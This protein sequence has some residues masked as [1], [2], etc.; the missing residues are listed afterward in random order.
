MKPH[1]LGW[2][3]HTW[4]ESNPRQLRLGTGAP[5]FHRHCADCGRDFL[6]D[7]N[8]GMSYAVF[9]SAISFYQLDDEVTERWIRETCVGSRRP[10]DVDDRKRKTVE[11]FVYENEPIFG[12]PPSGAEI[13]IA[14]STGAALKPATS[15]SK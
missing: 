2:N 8:S 6:T 7:V 15:M 5:I 12:N 1:D 3:G 9:V 4:N 14:A 11:I 10:A 13:S